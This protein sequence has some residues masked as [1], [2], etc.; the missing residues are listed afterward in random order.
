LQATLLG[1]HG[2]PAVAAAFRA[3]E[4]FGALGTL[5]SGLP[6]AAI[7]ERHRPTVGH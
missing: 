6:L 3:R 2:D 4:R 1:R 5:P 7:V